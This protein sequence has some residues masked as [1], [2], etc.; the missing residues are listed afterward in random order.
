MC[1]GVSEKK[2]QS[3]EFSSTWFLPS[4]LADFPT[5]ASSAWFC[6]LCCQPEPVPRSLAARVSQLTSWDPCRLLAWLGSAIC[7]VYR[8]RTGP[9]QSITMFQMATRDK[10]S[11]QKKTLFF[12]HAPKN[13]FETNLQNETEVKGKYCVPSARTGEAILTRAAQRLACLCVV[14]H[15]PAT[16]RLLLGIALSSPCV[17]IPRWRAL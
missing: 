16:H 12:F 13:S 4:V 7:T 17:Q 6:L 9:S 3:C 14:A 2:A 11:Q 1:A 8:S 10:I 15:F 5:T